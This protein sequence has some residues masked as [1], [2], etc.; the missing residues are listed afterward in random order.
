MT[1]F[2]VLN[3]GLSGVFLN[4]VLTLLGRGRL[5]NPDFLDAVFRDNGVEPDTMRILGIL[6]VFGIVG[7]AVWDIIDGWLKARRD[8]R[9]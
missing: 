2:A 9:R 6:L 1:G 3:T 5:L 4:R 8:T 7:V